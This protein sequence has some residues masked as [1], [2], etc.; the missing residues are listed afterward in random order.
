MAGSGSDR[1]FKFANDRVAAEWDGHEYK[2][3]ESLHRALLAEQ[4]LRLLSIQDESVSDAR[5]R[6]LLVDS[7]DKLM[8]DFLGLVGG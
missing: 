4:I 6:E 1:L 2:L 8:E 7:Y 5:V 3:G